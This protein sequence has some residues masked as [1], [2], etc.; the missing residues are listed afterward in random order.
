[1]SIATS[2]HPVKVKLPSG[3]TAKWLKEKEDSRCLKGGFCAAFTVSSFAVRA[4]SVCDRSQKNIVW[5]DSQQECCAVILPGK[6]HPLP[7]SFLSA[8]RGRGH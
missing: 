8:C 6:C 3:N 1:M 2:Y 5:V 4:L 7:A